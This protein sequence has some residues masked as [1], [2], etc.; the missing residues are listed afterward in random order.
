MT[1]AYWCVL[2]M[3]I[4]P[5]FFT[6]LAKSG[7]DFNNYSPRS[8]LEKQTGWRKRAHYIQLN[9][10]ETTPAF[11]LAIIIAHFAH[12]PQLTINYL[13]ILFIISRVIYALCYLGNKPLLRSLF[14]TIGMILI[15]SL[16]CISTA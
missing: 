7:G 6:G 8:F 5:Y 13:A 11:G 14:W 4:F 3:I 16:F 15:I 10:F 12:A 1:I 2:V 9:C